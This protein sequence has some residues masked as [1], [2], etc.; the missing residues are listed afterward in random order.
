MRTRSIRLMSIVFTVSLVAACPCLAAEPGLVGWW[1]F[2]EA[3]GSLLDQSDNHNDGTA[4]NGVLYQQPGQ[5][6]YALGFDGVDD[7][8][9]AGTNA[10]PTDT[11]SF[12]GWFKTTATHQIESQG[13]SGTGGTAG[14]RYAFDPQHGGDQN[15]GAG[16]SLGTNGI[17]V[18]EH[19]SSYMPAIAAYPTDLGT[20]WNH[21][22]IVYDNKQ[23]TI[24]LNGS[25]V[26]TGLKSPRAVVN[27]PIQFGGMAY[28]Y[29]QGLMDE[30]RIYS[31]ALSAAEVRQIA[32]RTGAW[33]PTPADG[34][35]YLATWVGLSWKPGDLA[36]S[37]DVY[38]GES[39]ADIDSGAPAALR[40]NLP[41]AT[42]S[43]FAGLGL[44]G[45]PYPAGLV[46]GTTYYW[47]IDEVNQANPGSPW[48]G[49]VWS[50]SIPS[51]KAHNPGPP[52][53]AQYAAGDVTLSWTGGL[54]AK[55]HYV[56]FGDNFDT[57]SN[58]AGGVPRALP[59]YTPAG[60]LER[61]KTYYWRVDE[62]DGAATH[63][64]D[65]WSFSTIPVIAVSDPDLLGWWKLEEGFGSVAVDFSGHENH[66]TINNPNGGLGQG[67]SAWAAD[68]E[69]DV[70]LSFNGD[71]TT[72][73]YVSAGRIPA[74]TLTNGFTWAFWT[75]QDAAQGRAIPGQGND[76][77]LGNRYGGTA[78]PVQFIKFTQG[79][80]EYY[81]AAL[82]GVIDYED[83]PAGVW[84]HHAVVK[85]AANLTYYRN[86]E[87]AGASTT[88]ATI[89]EN[90]LYM[91]GDAAGERWQGR[92]ADVRIYN[93][94]LTPQEVKQ[95]MRGDL[96]AAWNP[97]PN[98]RAV[99]DVERARQ[100][101]T[102]SV[103]DKASQHDVY[104]GLDKGAVD[105]AGAADT[106]GVYRGR[107]SAASYSPPETL[108]WGTGPYYW[109]ID[110][111]NSD[112][113][114]TAGSIWSFSV[115]DYLVVD[116]IESYNDLAE[117]DPA[118]NRIYTRWI[119]G[120]G[121][122]TN[123]AVVGNLDVPL[124]E[125]T[126][127][128]GGAQA[129][130][131]SY[132]NNR[133]FSE[134]TLT[135]TSGKDW[136]REGVANLSLWFRGAAANAPEKMY[137]ALNGTAVAYNNDTSLTQKTTWTEWVIPL[138][139]FSGQ[140]VNLTNVTSVTI[141]FGTRGNTTVAGGAG[142]MYFDDIRLQRPATAP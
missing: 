137:V 133:K 136:T 94:A 129:M 39:F 31:R 84:V 92:I 113:T 140:G 63:K 15:G 124:T 32:L 107:Q 46:P 48:K 128:H 122:T 82:N 134:A 2:E 53:G 59:T 30:V 13:T 130:P 109:R 86:G 138:Q 110:E 78:S 88:T 10:R 69:R 123:G 81:N 77:I 103:G 4:F 40:A 68:S 44:P 73:T 83:I 117:T 65:V 3:S 120:Y 52:D 64:G 132:D 72:G 51:R 47:R 75:N 126:N 61:G 111:V 54:N 112:G 12:G 106:T 97:S 25:A 98:N 139:Q 36:A 22:M 87:V 142:Q 67:G 58:A 35:T 18:Y 23:P 60:P 141:G 71:N 93:R 79:R 121:T 102:W 76:V 70:A 62:F 41:R 1:K 85:N 101:L 104:F 95:T 99:V 16:L 105:N 11:F 42:T 115:A 118:S 80:F 38:L 108:A 17:A 37:H 96:L 50:F 24:Y 19:G 135:L 21:I 9:V 116:D 49:D 127:V 34:A 20:E 57:V 7:Y 131:L 125:R 100:P 5:V 33:S 90:P 56:H 74:M 26:H 8:V 114:T 55:L 27:A 6:G 91:G 14:Q 89:D 66:G 29:F 43:F 119:D 45:D 28:G